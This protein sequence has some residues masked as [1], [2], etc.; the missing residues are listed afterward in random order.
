MF[1]HSKNNV[2]ILGIPMDMVID[3]IVVKDHKVILKHILTF[4]NPDIA[5]A[6]ILNF[7]PRV[8]HTR[9]K[10]NERKRLVKLA[11]TNWI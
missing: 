7:E 10:N 3:N 4:V 2:F 8:G 11:D 6:I 1:Y 5:S 9:H